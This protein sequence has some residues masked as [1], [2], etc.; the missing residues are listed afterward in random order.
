[1]KK[2]LRQSVGIDVGK[3]ELVSKFARL[4]EDFHREIPSSQVVK[5]NLQ[6]FSKLLSW[7]D[8]LKEKQI[9]LRFVIEATGVYYEALACYLVDKGQQVSVIL[10]NRAKAFSKTLTTKTVTDMTAAESLAVMGLEKQLDDWQKPGE[11]INHLKQ[12][13]RE[14]EQLLQER[15]M[16]K[17]QLHAEQHSAWPVE[18]SIKR[19]KDRIRYVTK[20][21]KQVELE[22]RQILKGNATLQEKM[23]KI[24][25][26]VGV[27]QVT[28]ISVVAETAGF[29]LIRNKKQLTSYAGYDIVDKISGTSV[30]GKPHISHKGNKNLRK[31]MHYPAL[32]AIKHDPKMKQ[33]YIRLLSKHGIKMKALVAV[34]RKML[35][36]IYT[37]WKND[38]EYDPDYEIKIKYLGQPTKETALTELDQ[39]RSI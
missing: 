23:D 29:N 7:C 21:I 19:M 3:D 36:L 26:M 32:S 25:T 20:Q 16:I 14:R 8:K 37:L 30:R 35:V 34:Q 22:M 11:E 33:F 6:G 10:P 4:C 5:N 13:N 31:A 17:N 2:L 1:M 24:C 12:L 28:A 15:S 39:V 18:Q 38:Q 27:G 9:E